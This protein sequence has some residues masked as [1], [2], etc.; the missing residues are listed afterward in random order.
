M[1]KIKTFKSVILICTLP[2]IFTYCGGNN[3]G[4]YA[5]ELC[6]CFKKLGIEDS[7]ELEDLVTDYR[8]Q[9]KIEDKAERVLP[10]C[11]LKVAEKIEEEMDDMDKSEKTAFMQ[12]FMKSCIDTECSEIIL[13]AIPYD[14]MG[15][16]IKAAKNEV[17]RMEGYRNNDYY[18]EKY[19]DYYEEEY[20]DYYEEEYYDAEEAW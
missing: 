3:S 16:G 1:N 7:D 14:M 10:K 5:E 20:D 19:D 17:E 12:A 8:A 18:E 6:E 11:I 2:L 4:G 13:G 15:A 9:R